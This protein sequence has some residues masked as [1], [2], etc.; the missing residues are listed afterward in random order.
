MN[1]L[2]KFISGLT[3]AIIACFAQTMPFA[4]ICLF[5]V[6]VDC[7]SAFR[8]SLRVKVKFP[9]QCSGKLKSDSARRMFGTLLMIYAVILLLH[10]VDKYCFTFMNMYLANIAAGVFCMVQIISILENESS[11]NRAKWAKVLQ[12]MLVDKTKRHLDVDLSSLITEKKEKENEN[13]D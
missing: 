6:I 9:E 4:M 3:G 7:I 11:C 10:T 8:L 5:A 12:K 13:T 2:V 1:V